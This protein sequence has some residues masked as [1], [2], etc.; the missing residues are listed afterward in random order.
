MGVENGKPMNNAMGFE[1]AQNKIASNQSKSKKTAEA[2][3]KVASEIDKKNNSNQTKVG[4]GKSMNTRK[5]VGS[6]I[7][8]GKKEKSSRHISKKAEL[9]RAA[10]ANEKTRQEQ[11]D[12]DNKYKKR[13]R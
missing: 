7:K 2:S 1:K 10:R 9:M 6:D 11:R 4:N 13:K 3:K 5:S 12:K 8:N